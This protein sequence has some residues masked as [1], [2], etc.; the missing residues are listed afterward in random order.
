MNQL[1][2]RRDGWVVAGWRKADRSRIVQGSSV[3]REEVVVFNE[4]HSAAQQVRESVVHPV[5]Y[6]VVR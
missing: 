2:S 5:A 3:P 6:E 4:I 1:A